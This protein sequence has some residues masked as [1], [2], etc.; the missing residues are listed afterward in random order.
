M[1]QAHSGQV[2]LRNAVKVQGAGPPLVL[3]HGFG[4]DQSMWARVAPGLATDHQVIQ[5]DL[6]GMGASDYHHYDRVRHGDLQ[7]HADDLIEILE[8]LGGPPVVAVGHSVSSMISALA[9]IKR[10]DLFAALVMIGPSPCYVDKPPYQGGFSESD[11]SGLL[12]TMEENYKG[13]A[14]Q[15][16]SMVAGD[17][18]DDSPREELNDRFCR[19]DPEIAKH[20]AK[21]T[22]LADNRADLPKVK[23]PTLII[24]SA[25]DAI[26]QPFVGAYVH[27]QIAGSKLVTVDST[28]HAPHM[29]KP[30]E[31]TAAIR[32]FLARL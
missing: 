18:D 3:L 29:T 22:F 25:H 17:Q 10:P 26:A 31:T 24:Q 21:V 8:A 6:T 4:C 23:T 20:F 19:N 13:W 28:G 12:S 14:G 32:D 11:I 5:Y 7:G 30:A 16:A 2:L 1:V 27:E 9:A 15:L